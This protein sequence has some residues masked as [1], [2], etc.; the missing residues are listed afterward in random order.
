[1]YVCK[2]VFMYTRDKFPCIYVSMCVCIQYACSMY[3]YMYECIYV[4]MYVYVYACMHMY[5]CASMYV[6]MYAYK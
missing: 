1:M 2:Y 4:C 3:V 5:L 6:C